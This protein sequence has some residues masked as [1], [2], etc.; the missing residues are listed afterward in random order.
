MPL[1]NLAGGNIALL[2]PDWLKLNQNEMCWPYR[3]FGNMVVCIKH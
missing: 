3:P 1:N 2:K